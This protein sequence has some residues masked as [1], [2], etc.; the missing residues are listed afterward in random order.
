MYL[1]LRDVPFPR[2]WTFK[3]RIE[4]TVLQGREGQKL[5]RLE[6]RVCAEVELQERA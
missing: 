2:K 3:V 1:C 4:A 6:E 5:S